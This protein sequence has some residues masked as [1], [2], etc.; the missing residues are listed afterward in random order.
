M[1]CYCTG[2]VSVYG[3]IVRETAGIT[4]TLPVRGSVTAAD[5]YAI[6]GRAN[7]ERDH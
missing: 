1:A 4:H 5:T 6:V 3:S 7:N 2:L